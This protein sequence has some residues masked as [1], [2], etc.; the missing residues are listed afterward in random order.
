MLFLKVGSRV[1]FLR[2]SGYFILGVSGKLGWWECEGPKI[3]GREENNPEEKA[4]RSALLKWR[5]W[6]STGFTPGPCSWTKGRC[7][8]LSLLL[9]LQGGCW[10]D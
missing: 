7:S 3:K 10:H 5:A 6:Q 4:M 1:S 9:G 8:A 2:A